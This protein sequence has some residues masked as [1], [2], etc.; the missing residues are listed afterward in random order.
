MFNIKTDII[1]NYLLKK[2]LNELSENKIFYKIIEGKYM[3]DEVS[4]QNYNSIKK[5]YNSTREILD[6]FNPINNNLWKSLYKDFN[7][8][9]VDL[10]LTVG[11]PKPYD[12]IT[13]KINNKNSIILDLNRFIS[14]KKSYKETI[15]IFKR[16]LTHELSH[17]FNW[18]IFDYDLPSVKDKINY[19]LM[20]EGIAHFISYPNVSNENFN[21][22]I[23]NRRMVRN[24]KNF[25]NKYEKVNENNFWDF[26]QEGNSG[27]YWDK[28]IAISGKFAIINYYKLNNNS[29]SNFIDDYKKDKNILW[30]YMEKCFIS[31]NNK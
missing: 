22:L 1:D 3:K 31:Y 5:L 6:D 26:I 13:R 11:L 30:K 23:Y 25:F 2:N 14:Y 9:L 17:I 28:Y 24:I 21:T 15:G 8:R 16:I 20:D 12:A 29:L 10:Y 18:E 4:N 19:L 7:L 27:S